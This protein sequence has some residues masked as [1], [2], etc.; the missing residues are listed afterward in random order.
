MSG[1][2]TCD[3]V[4]TSSISSSSD[5]QI[6]SYIW[7]STAPTSGQLMVTDGSGN[8]TFTYKNS[9]VAIGSLVTTHATDVSSGIVSVTGTLATTVTLPD[10]TLKIVGDVIHIVKEVSGA[11]VVT[12]SPFSTELISGSTSDTISAS[13]GTVKVYTN[14]TDWFKI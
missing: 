1:T 9:R 7:P 2:I 3:S 11:S 12:I 5:I 6:G 13:Y 10:P 8:L 4:T 14:G